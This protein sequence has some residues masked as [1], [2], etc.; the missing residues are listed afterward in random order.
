MECAVRRKVCWLL[1]QWLQSCSV[2]KKLQLAHRVIWIMHFGSAG[3]EVDHI[4]HV[5]SDN[6]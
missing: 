3:M 6:R 1:F 5:K 4:N 2:N